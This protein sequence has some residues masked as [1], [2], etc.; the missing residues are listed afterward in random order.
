MKIKEGSPAG[1]RWDFCLRHRVQAGSGANSA[2]C[3]MD[4]GV[5]TPWVKRPEREVDHSSP[6]SAEV[7][8]A[9]SY[10]STAIRVH[11]VALN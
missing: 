6:S 3:P 4:T 7:K 10:T 1:K 8:K 2:S 9:S 11:G 5:S